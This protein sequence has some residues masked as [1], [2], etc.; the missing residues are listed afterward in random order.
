M[1]AASVRPSASR[2]RA[3]PGRAPPPRAAPPPPKSPWPGPGRRS[4][5]SNGTATCS[6]AGSPPRLP[7]SP[8][9]IPALRAILLSESRVTGSPARTRLPPW[10]S[11]HRT[12]RRTAL[13]ARTP[14]LP[15]A[16]RA[17]P[18]R[19]WLDRQGQTALRTILLLRE[20]P[21]IP[22]QAKL[23][24]KG[25]PGNSLVLM[26]DSRTR[27]LVSK[28]RPSSRAYK[29]SPEGQRREPQATLQTRGLHRMVSL[30]ERPRH[31]PT[32][33][34][35]QERWASLRLQAFRL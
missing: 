9:P 20:R 31:L 8:P 1:R 6:A 18:A 28:V 15:P 34:V 32:Q 14:R 5:T 11:T 17:P 22:R 13:P 10:P 24:R 19:R 16:L 29:A 21:P 35:P 3:S 33:A 4:P 23:E 30:A 7:P 2:S 25:K 12:G 27:R 26:R